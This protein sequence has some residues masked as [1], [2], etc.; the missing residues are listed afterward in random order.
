MMEC[1]RACNTSF[2]SPSPDVKL[3]LAVT[4]ILKKGTPGIPIHETGKGNPFRPYV[5]DAGR[6]EIEMEA[7][8][9]YEKT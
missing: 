9:N 2:T 5:I 8:L 3:M 7:L 4:E 1:L 6:D